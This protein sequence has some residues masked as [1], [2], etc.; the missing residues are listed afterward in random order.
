MLIHG[1]LG[2]MQQPGVD[3][4]DVTTGQDHP[5]G[6]GSERALKGRIH[7]LTKRIPL[8]TES[9]VGGRTPLRRQ[10]AGIR[11]VMKEEQ[12][13]AGA[14]YIGNTIR[15][16]GPV[17]IAGRLIAQVAGQA[18]LDPSRNRRAHEDCNNVV[19]LESVFSY[20]APLTM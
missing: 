13:K 14:P 2:R 1:P 20:A 8:L 3:A 4:G 10:A 6:A 19:L 17:K 5:L 9:S 12:G 7:P 18:R 16:H 15:N 11:P